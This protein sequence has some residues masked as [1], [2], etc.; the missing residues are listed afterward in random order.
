MTPLPGP[1]RGNASP[2]GL[3]D[4]PAHRGRVAAARQFLAAL[5]LAVLTV[6]GGAPAAAGA[7]IPARS[8]AGPAHLAGDRTG[9][10]ATAQHAD[11]SVRPSAGR[12]RSDRDSRTVRRT[13]AATAAGVHRAGPAAAPQPWAA[14]EH[15][16]PP[17]HLPPP[18][19]GT[20]PPSPPGIPLPPPVPGPA[21][22]AP[23][24][25]ADR[26][27]AALPGVRG[28]PRAA[29]HRPGD[30]PQQVPPLNPAGPV[31]PP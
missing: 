9:T 1:P 4:T 16:R 15:P 23:A 5:L 18:G 25:A 11:R 14:P 30:L 20:L 13:G 29:V 26:F 12:S 8:P 6:A 10:P 7:G 19:T 22:A 28:P 17:Q 2:R 27:R 24:A 3:P 31:P 21:V